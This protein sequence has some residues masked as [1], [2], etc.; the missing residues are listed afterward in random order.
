[1]RSLATGLMTEDPL[2]TVSRE[3]PPQVMLGAAVETVE[4]SSGIMKGVGQSSGVTNIV[5]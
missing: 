5:V 4:A 3:L 1:M 2:R